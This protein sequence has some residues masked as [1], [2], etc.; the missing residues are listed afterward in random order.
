MHN[1]VLLIHCDIKSYNILIKGNFD[2]CK[3]CDFGVSLPIDKDGNVE[4]KT[5]KNVEYIGTPAWS[6]PEVLKYPQIITTKTDIY[7][8]G[9]VFWEM[10][11]LMP[12]ID[13]D[14]F[15]TS[16]DLDESDI[17]D[18]CMVY[19]KDRKRP[20]LPEFEFNVEYEPILNIYNLCTYEDLHAR[21]TAYHL[22]LCFDELV[23]KG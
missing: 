11:A 14:T 1:E 8:F 22:K 19:K 15:N 7:A 4:V 18:T 10:L 6:A 17:D 2:N 3:L 5:G 21:P 13:E 9:L 12:P 23:N 16:I 20:P